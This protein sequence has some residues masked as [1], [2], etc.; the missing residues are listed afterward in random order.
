M[1]AGCR[2]S[3]GWEGGCFRVITDHVTRGEKETPLSYP[4]NSLKLFGSGI[5][6]R[7][8]LA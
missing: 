1:S 2:S 3:C 4:L 6:D 5:P 7:E 8:G